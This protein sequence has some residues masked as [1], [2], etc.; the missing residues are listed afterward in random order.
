MLLFGKLNL[1][2]KDSTIEKMKRNLLFLINIL[3]FIPIFT[4][5]QTPL[6]NNNGA[7]ITVKSGGLMVVKKGT[8]ATDASIDNMGVAG[9]QIDNAGRIIVEHDYINNAISSGVGSAS[10]FEVRRNWE[11]NATFNAGTSTV[12]L[13]GNNYQLITGSQVTSFYNLYLDSMKVKEQAIN[14][15]TTNKLDIK[16]CELRTDV[17]KMWLK[18]SA[19][20]SL[21]FTTGF[22]CSRGAGQFAWNLTTNQNYFYPIGDSTFTPFLRYRPLQLSVSAPAEFGARMANLDA[23]LEN[24]D[25][26]IHQADVCKINNLYYHLIYRNSGTA[27]ADIK[28]YYD[29]AQ[30]GIWEMGAH[31]QN[32]PEWQKMIGAAAGTSGTFK[33][34]SYNNWNNFNPPAFALANISPLIDTTNLSIIPEYCAPSGTIT[35][36]TALNTMPG[37]TYTWTNAS[38]QIVGNALNVG[39]LPTGNYTLTIV[40]PTGCTVSQSF[41]VGY[42][43]T[44]A[45]AIEP[46]NV[47]C[48][49]QSNGMANLQLS[50]GFAPFSYHWNTGASTQDLTNVPAGTY[51]VVVTDAQGCKQRDTVVVTQPTRIIV[52]STT[53]SESCERQNGSATVMASGG[54]PGYVYSWDTNPAQTTPQANGLSEG[55]Y[56]ALITDAN[57]CSVSRMVTI[58]NI[59]SPIAMFTSDPLSGTPILQYNAHFLFENQSQNATSYVWDFG[60]GNSSIVKNPKYDFSDPGTYTVSLT[61]YNSVG[62]KDVYEVP[63]EVIPNGTIYIPTAFSP[64]GDGIN[65]FMES[66]GEGIVSFNMV[67]F[68]RWGKEIIT[69]TDISQVWD[70]TKNGKGVPEGAYTYI[71][72]AVLNYGGRLRHGGTITI[73]R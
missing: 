14:A 31:W 59:P 35:G 39:H 2:I 45:T 47:L 55:T 13:N 63:Y 34:Y 67:I 15:I 7:L 53:E 42:I 22:I 65:D 30:D 48:Y 29:Q 10:I 69:L 54:T 50:G 64:N 46:T 26:N 5:A 24:Y 8:A 72:E 21:T 40:K 4:H 16:N 18:N 44:Y 33:T 58:K 60:D 19:N 43:P 57:G 12:L 49:G 9:S 37:M 62:C 32:V 41:P 52:T 36:I 28:F 73:I 51:I 38:G 56:N 68:D 3:A 27:T 71:V 66:K 17:N 6:V 61:A 1:Y 25:R 70:G 23:T 20:N 11:N